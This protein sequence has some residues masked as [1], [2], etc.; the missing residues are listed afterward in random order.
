MVLQTNLVLKQVLISLEIH[1]EPSDFILNFFPT[2]KII[3][4]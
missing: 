2:A 4:K 3:I 1:L